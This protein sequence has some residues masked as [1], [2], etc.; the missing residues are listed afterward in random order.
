M[1]IQL[2]QV[3]K[4]YGALH[5]LDDVSL[6]IERK[7]IVTLLGPNG[8]GKSTLLLCLAG[9]VA[10]TEGTIY[11]DGEPFGRDKLHLRQ[12]M[13]FL[14]DF[15]PLFRTET[16]MRCIAMVLRVYGA[17]DAGAEARVLELLRDFDLIPLAKRTVGNLSR[18]QTYKVALVAMIAANC[19]LWLLDEPFASGMDPQGIDA[20]KH[21]AQAA[22]ANGAT[23]I[24]STQLLDVAER[25]SDQA[26][27]IDEGK[28]CAFG[29][30]NSLREGAEDK[31][32]VLQN[33]LRKLRESHQ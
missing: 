23:I 31:A 12:K 22:K 21:H 8:A 6:A 30:V 26:C 1:Q 7:Q 9:L 10:P 29:S 20:F 2:K 33:L 24:Y 25:F 14:P 32:N 11:F 4:K 18:G 27:V 3:S 17:D 5:A 28:V 13:F 15:P 19:S 16:V